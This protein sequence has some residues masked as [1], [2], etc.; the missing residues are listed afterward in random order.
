VS[1]YYDDSIEKRIDGRPQEGCDDGVPAE[2]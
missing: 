2:Y 1:N